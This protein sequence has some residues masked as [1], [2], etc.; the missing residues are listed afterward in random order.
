MTFH[1]TGFTLL[2][3]VAVI[4]TAVI[5]GTL[6]WLRSGRRRSVG[7]LELLRFLLILMAIITL[8]QPERTQEIRPAEKPTV[9]VLRDTSK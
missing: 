7:L 2:L 1:W 3:S 6:T 8:N 9:V 4:A 5:F